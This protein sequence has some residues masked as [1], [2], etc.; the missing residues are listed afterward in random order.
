LLYL[1]LREPEHA[2]ELAQE[3]CGL[4][5]SHGFH[6][7]ESLATSYHGIALSGLG[8]EQ[9][10]IAETLAGIDSYRATGSELGA[11]AVMVGLVT[12]YFRSGQTDQALETANRAITSIEQTEARL[13]EAELRRLKGETL[14]VNAKSLEAQACFERAIEIARKQ[15]AKSW[16]LRATMSLARLLRDSG[17]RG[18]ARATLAKIFSWFTEGFDS[19]DLEDARALLDRLDSEA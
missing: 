3:A 9:E 15:S 11:A 4:A 16:E 6:Y 14:L 19:A 1:C 13:G 2:L 10:G 7:W 12:S 17:R 5:A 18:E 8:R